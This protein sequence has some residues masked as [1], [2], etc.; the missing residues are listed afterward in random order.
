MQYVGF[1]VIMVGLI[2][3]LA[4]VVFSWKE[5]KDRQT[6]GATE[7]V[8]SIRD[9]VVAIAESKSPSLAC[10]AFGTI[11]VVVGGVISGATAIF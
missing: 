5:Y 10:F 1:A 9:L 7:F 4:G 8:Q 3:M 2:L 6:L 11:M